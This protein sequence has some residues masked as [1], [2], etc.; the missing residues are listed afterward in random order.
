MSSLSAMSGDL[1]VEAHQLHKFF[2]PNEVL[3][4]IDLSL[5]KGKITALLGINGAGKSTLMQILAG[6]LEPSSGTLKHLGAVAMVH[7]ELSF[8]PEMS[9][10][11][12]I[13]LEHLN[14]YKNKWGVLDH[15]KLQTKARRILSTVGLESIDVACSAKEFS[16]GQLQMMEIA[17]ALYKI[18]LYEKSPLLILDEPT[19]ALTRSECERLFA[20][21]KDLS[22]NKG[23]SI[24]L[25]SHRLDEIEEVAD[26]ACI[27]REGILAAHLNRQEFQKDRFIELMT[28]LPQQQAI[29]KTTPQNNKAAPHYGDTNLLVKINPS[30]QILKKSAPHRASLLQLQSKDLNIEAGACIGIAGLLGSGRSLFLTALAHSL[31]AAHQGLPPPLP[32]LWVQGIEKQSAI[33]NC[34]FLH[35]DRKTHGL[36]GDLSALENIAASESELSRLSKA[37]KL[38][39]ILKVKGTTESVANSLSGGNQQKL[40]IGRALLSHAKLL[41]L[42]E[43]TRGVD[44]GAREEIHTIMK[45]H[46]AQGGAILWTSSDWE[47]LLEHST[48]IWVIKD[49][50]VS[51][52]QEYP[53][54][55]PALAK[56]VLGANKQRQ[57]VKGYVS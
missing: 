3:R 42:D 24:L 37:R 32:G 46:C 19:S 36:F 16:T 6:L 50:T 9:I 26:E 53:K 1:V 48:Q 23:I 33:V 56:E 54:H 39:P 14:L 38:F 4:G 47:E 15:L 22:H 28:G 45:S 51:A 2:G 29:N 49:K 10:A 25:V 31:P 55:V 18:S 35:E 34:S 21:M 30:F 44:P 52:L 11:E 8:L 17:R 40:L 7:Q 43:P 12:N 41:L 13:L 27:L 5:E 57:G 20:L